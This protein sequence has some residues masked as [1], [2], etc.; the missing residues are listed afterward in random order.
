[1]SQRGYDK[2]I[3]TTCIC[4]YFINTGMFDGV[5]QTFPMYILDQHEVVDRIIA[6][7]C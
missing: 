1:M 2:F 3:K 5:K 4:P 7:I 6:A